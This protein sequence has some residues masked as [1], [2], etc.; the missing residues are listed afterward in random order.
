[1]NDLMKLLRKA[2]GNFPNPWIH[3]S[4]INDVLHLAESKYKCSISASVTAG[5]T[6]YL[7]LF[8]GYATA[9]IEEEIRYSEQY[10]RDALIKVNIEINRALV[11]SEH[12]HLAQMKRN[13]GSLHTIE[14]YD[15][16]KIPIEDNITEVLFI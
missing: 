7:Y 11:K 16:S 6:S 3:I 5:M 4:Y 13:I 1:M 8:D 10:Q 14:I 2:S 9:I 12:L 15:R